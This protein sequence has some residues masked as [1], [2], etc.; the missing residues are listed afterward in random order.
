M[1]HG[2]PVHR[3]WETGRRARPAT[4]WLPSFG[5]LPRPCG[6]PS[7]SSVPFP[8]SSCLSANSEYPPALFSFRIER[9]GYSGETFAFGSS[10]CEIQ[11]AG[12]LLPLLIVYSMHIGLPADESDQEVT[13][14]NQDDAF[15][16]VIAADCN[17]RFW[18]GAFP[19]GRRD[20]IAGQDILHPL[21]GMELK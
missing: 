15:V 6:K 14:E 10:G 12:C 8:P 17:H 19:G 13:Y 4:G 5:P 2:S 18:R 20:P 16:L 7:P 3:H 1:C 9:L 21:L 11:K